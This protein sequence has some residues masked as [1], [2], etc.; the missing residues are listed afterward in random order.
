[1]PRKSSQKRSRKRIG[2][3][4][5]KQSERNFWAKERP[6]RITDSGGLLWT[7]LVRVHPQER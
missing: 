6:D 1:L 3:S 4:K 5:I 7:R 2:E